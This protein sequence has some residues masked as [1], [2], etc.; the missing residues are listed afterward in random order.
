MAGQGAYGVAVARGGAFVR[1]A[2][3]PALAPPFASVG[4]V[5]WIRAN[6]FST[7]F[8]ATV[9]V[10]TVLLLAWVVPPVV[11]FLLIDAVWTGADREACLVTP[12]HPHVRACWAVVHE[13]LASFTYS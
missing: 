5:G 8:N 10:L 13:R 4:W 9:T 3:A 11:R 2:P 7:P 12:V 6:L 1:H